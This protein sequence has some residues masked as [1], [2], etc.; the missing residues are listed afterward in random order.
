MR[1]G[2]EQS[3]DA[4]EYET[5]IFADRYAGEQRILESRNVAAV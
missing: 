3:G 4:D 2:G 5:P 1:C